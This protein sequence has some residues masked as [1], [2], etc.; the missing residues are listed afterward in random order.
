MVPGTVPDKG[1][2]AMNKIDFVSVLMEFTL[3]CKEKE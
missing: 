3:W 1:T 2:V